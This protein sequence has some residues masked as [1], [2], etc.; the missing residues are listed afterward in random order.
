MKERRKRMKKLLTTAAVAASLTGVILAQTPPYIWYV[1]VSPETAQ[2]YDGNPLVEN[3]HYYNGQTWVP[4][5][6]VWDVRS[7]FGNGGTIWQNAASGQI[8]TNAP[9]LRVPLSLQAP[10]EY[11]IYAYFWSDSSGWRAQAGLSLDTLTLYIHQAGLQ[12]GLIQLGSNGPEGEH[13]HP[14]LSS[15]EYLTEINGVPIYNTP[16]DQGLMVGE[17][18]RRLLQATLG[19]LNITE[20]TTVYVYLGPDPNQQDSNER[21]WLDGVG[22]MYVPEPSTWAILILAGLTG[23]GLLRRNRR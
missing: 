12:E 20:P 17:G 4:N 19:T 18:N 10:G 15:P 9:I 1:E 11:T 5:D 3:T 7:L 14:D 13:D 16:S 23:I 2:L 6:G 22:Y 21:T 8:D